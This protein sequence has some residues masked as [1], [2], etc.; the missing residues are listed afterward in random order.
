MLRVNRKGS[1]SSRAMLTAQKEE[2]SPH[3]LDL[4]AGDTE[5][6]DEENRSLGFIQT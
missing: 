5:P 6:T 2:Q 3:V 1:S 4:E